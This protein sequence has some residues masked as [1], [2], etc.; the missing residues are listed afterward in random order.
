MHRHPHYARTL[1]RLG[2]PVTRLPGGALSVARRI[3]PLRLTWLPQPA[4]LPP[5]EA[6]RGLVL[7]QASDAGQDAQLRSRGAIPLLTPQYRAVMAL[8]PDADRRLA[9]QHQKW[10]NR[11]RHGQRQG[12]EI[13][14][15]PLPRDPDHWLLAAE[16][17]QQHARGY[18][19]LPAEFALHWPQGRLFI[20]RREAGIVA[21]QLFLLHPPGASYHIGWSNDAGRAASA[22]NLLLWQA[23]RWLAA[24]GIT[25]LDLGPL[26]ETAPG[27]TRFKLGAGA[28]ALP[29]G[30]TWLASRILAP[31][32]RVIG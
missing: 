19:A 31:L 25:R 23:G 26:D 22:H 21:A 8:C 32:G 16:A 28:S 14:H 12:L 29:G 20:A 15:A 17:A 4:T 9:L 2:R 27:L 18:R 10:R 30:H 13:T 1:Q 11:L 24:R 7:I 6:L 5:A 3:G